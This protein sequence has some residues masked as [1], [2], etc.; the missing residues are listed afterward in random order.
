MV[1]QKKDQSIRLCVDY[2]QLNAKTRK[3]AFPLPRIEETLDAL[4]GAKWFS[5]L[6]LASGYNQVLVQEQDREKT[7]F[8]T[9]FGLFEFNRM[10]F[11][12]CNAPGTFQ[13]LMERIFGDHSFHALLLYL[14]DVVIFSTTFQQHLERLEMVLQ[15]LEQHNLKLKL[16]KCKFF[17][18]EVSY[19]GHV[20]SASGVATDPE[21]IRAVAEWK[22]PSTVKELRSFLGFASYY[23]RFVAGFAAFAAPLHKLVGALEGTRKKPGPRLRGQVD[24]HW[25]QDCEEAFQAQKSRLV[26]APV[27]GYADFTRPFIVEVDASH[28]GLGA[29]L[30]QEQDG[31]RR[32]IAYASRGLRPS[33]RNM[34]N[35]SAMKLE[36]LG[37]KWAVT[38]KFREYLLG[39][40]FT[41]YTD[42]NPL[43]YL[44]S[45]KLAAVEQRWVSQLA[46]FD[47]DIKYR[48]G[49]TNRNAD[50]LSRLPVAVNSDS[51][52]VMGLGP[53]RVSIQGGETS[54]L[55]A[56]IR[57]QDRLG[58][59]APRL[60]PGEAELLLRETTWR[61]CSTLPPLAER[62]MTPGLGPQGV[63]PL[64]DGMFSFGIQVPPWTRCQIAP[65]LGPRLAEV[66]EVGASV[67][68]SKEDL[69]VLQAADPCLNAFLRFWK[70]GHPPSVAE[71]KVSP[72]GVRGWVKQWRKI[73][74]KDGLLYREVQLPP[75]R[76]TALQLL[77]PAAL[78]AEVLTNLHNNHG[79]QG[80]DRTTSLVRQR[81]YWPG[82][83]R[84]IKKWCE[85]CERCVVAKA[86]QPKVRTFRGNLLATRPLEIVAI[87]FTT[88]ERASS[89]HENVLVVTDVFSKFTQ[90]YPT[91]DQKAKSVVK[92]LTEKWF[93]TYGVPQRI[94]SDQGRCFE[95]ELLHQLCTLYGVHKRTTPYHPEGNGQCERF[96]RTL[97]DLLRTL[98]VERKRKWPQLLPQLLFAYNTTE[99]QS[100]GFSPYELMFGQ[101]PRLPVDQLLGVADRDSPNSDLGDWMAQH[102]EHLSTA[103]GHAR[104][105]L[106]AA[107]AHRNKDHVEPTPILPSGTLVYC[108]NH[109]HGRHKIQDFWS[110]VVH[111]VIECLNQVGTLYRLKPYGEDGPCKVVHRNEIK[112]LPRGVKVGQDVPPA[113]QPVGGLP[114]ILTPSPHAAPYPELR[115]TEAPSPDDA[116]DEDLWRLSVPQSLPH[117][118]GVPCP[119]ATAHTAPYPVSHH[120][121]QVQQGLDGEDDEGAAAPPITSNDGQDATRPSLLEFGCQPTSPSSSGAS[122][123]ASPILLPTSPSTQNRPQFQEPL[124]C[125]KSLFSPAPGASVPSDSSIPLHRCSSRNTAGKHS[126]PHNLPRSAIPNLGLD[127]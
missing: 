44:Q 79:H 85:E 73:K 127:Q 55:T 84:D 64:Q 59:E 78:R 89:G 83:S 43:R 98:P 28:A 115:R 37:L 118:A 113:S 107:A 119:P 67:S 65:G 92:V 87:D 102:R 70:R 105:Q 76:A 11:G 10:P 7:A 104:H 36:L 8:C 4:S 15:R 68:R 126:N 13:R 40:K 47:Y 16:K 74:E 112:P 46:L 106:E 32:P 93:Y 45:A 99:H 9:P 111:E 21:K 19:L 125:D 20:I 114:Y 14:D 56:S 94:H 117:L 60:G 50:A 57:Q 41:V 96:N 53:L 86:N 77:L 110:S 54:A 120:P 3:D 101:K 95:G 1:V 72:S 48:P 35:Y 22:R 49:T 17:Q 52:T 61:P 12:L 31:Q 24:Q 100:T 108:K 71:V 42:N 5:T 51:G 62:E 34:S 109:H 23:R 27:L 81:C 88:L 29:V 2:R 82:M 38:E 91:T 123:P 90:A 30:S 69:Q 121:E 80:V 39:H 18:S 66:S 26:Q 75:S 103:Y 58:I 122:P 124:D 33:E 116:G 97:H 25:N 63:E 6:D